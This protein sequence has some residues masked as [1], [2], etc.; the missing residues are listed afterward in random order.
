MLH[1]EEYELGHVEFD[2]VRIFG[3]FD[4]ADRPVVFGGRDRSLRRE[5]ERFEM[6]LLQFNSW[7]P[8]DCVPNAY[9]LELFGRLVNCVDYV[10]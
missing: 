7:W 8:A 4:Y 6:N 1:P 10:N 5:R 9:V 2:D 3:R